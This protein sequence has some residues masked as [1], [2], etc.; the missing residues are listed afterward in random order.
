MKRTNSILVL[1]LVLGLAMFVGC[2]GSGDDSTADAMEEATEAARQAGEDVAKTVT[3][4]AEDL[5]N[6]TAEDI[7]AKIEEW[8]VTIAEKQGRVDEITAK[9]KGMNP[10]ELMGDEAKKLKAESASIL[11]EISGLKEKVENA[12]ANVGE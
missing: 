4:A 10:T 5:E 6:M 12:A 3:T 1:G 7:Q 2:G 9:L 8:K 11:G